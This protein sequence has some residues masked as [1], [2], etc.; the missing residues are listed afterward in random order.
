MSESSGYRDESS[1]KDNAIEEINEKFNVE[2]GR[3]KATVRQQEAECDELRKQLLF[4]RQKTEDG[5]LLSLKVKELEEQLSENKKAAEGYQDIISELEK[6]VG[7]EHANFMRAQEDKAN[8]NSRVISFKGEIDTIYK[9]LSSLNEQ[10]GANE[11]LQQEL[12]LERLRAEK[13]ENEMLEFKKMASEMKAKF[14]G[15]QTQMDLQFNEMEKKQ[16]AMQLDIIALRENLENFRKT[17]GAEID[18]LIADAE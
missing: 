4:S 18:A 15:E 9:Q 13:A 11:N 3:L 10:V 6:R 14:H 12:E 2:I 17:T 8:L 5:Q 1:K 16:K 7:D